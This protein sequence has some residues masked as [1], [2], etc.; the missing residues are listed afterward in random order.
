MLEGNL[1][2]AEGRDADIVY[3]KELFY[4]RI[5]QPF[6]RWLM[7]ILPETDDISKTCKKLDEIIQKVGKELGEEMV[8][9]AGEAAFAGRTK[10]DVYYASPEA[11]NWFLGKLHKIYH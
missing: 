7:E 2:R 9:N 4:D 10:D 8:S 11:Y 6:R 3:V 1:A 5:D